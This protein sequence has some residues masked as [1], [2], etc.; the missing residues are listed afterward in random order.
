MKADD[1]DDKRAAPAGLADAAGLAEAESFPDGS[2][3]GH[4][5]GSLAAAVGEVEIEVGEHDHHE[6]HEVGEGG[7]LA[8]LVLLVGDADR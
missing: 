7:A 4:G 6:Q 2:D 8:G 5:S 3:V 1:G